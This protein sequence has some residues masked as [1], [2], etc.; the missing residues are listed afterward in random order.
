MSKRVLLLS[1]V[2][3]ALIVGSVGAIADGDDNNPPSAE[4]TQVTTIEPR[5]R[6]AL[7]VLDEDRDAGD[8]LPD[9]VAEPM[10]EE[11][12]FGMNPDLSRLSI[13]NMTSSVYV[14]P[15][16]DHVCASITVGQGANTTCPETDDVVDGKAGAATVVL[17]TGDVAIYG[18]VP[19]GVESV[20]VQTG[21]TTSTEVATEDNAYYTVVP[22]GTQLRT[23]SYIGPS[24]PVEF[25]IYDPALALEG[26]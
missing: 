3:L 12:D 25:P 5:A 21:T 22:H 8:A 23:V 15:A 13:G 9:Q 1:I 16:R 7:D 11:A 10:D 4:A 18:L 26:H 17:E 24:G 6:A 14:I 20:S 2:A 19:D